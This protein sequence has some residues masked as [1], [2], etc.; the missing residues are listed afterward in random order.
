MLA[1][2]TKKKVLAHG[3]IHLEALPFA[4]GETVEIIV[5]AA[6]EQNAKPDADSSA[7]V[8]S[9]KGS[10]LAYLDPTEPV[11]QDEWSALQ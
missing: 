2:R 11:A 7:G 4:V 3:K 9:L 5:L 8:H 10:V 1:Y 6:A